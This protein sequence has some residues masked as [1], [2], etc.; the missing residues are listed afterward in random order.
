[1]EVN[2]TNSK[3]PF[4]KRNW[5]RLF[6]E[7]SGFYQSYSFYYQS[8]KTEPALSTLPS[9]QINNDF[10]VINIQSLKCILCN[11]TFSSSAI[12]MLHYISI[13]IQYRLYYMVTLDLSF[14]DT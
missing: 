14:I 10:K 12:L 13:H 5:S 3:F 11:S 2:T 1:M 9:S 6:K 7:K 8:S 4:L